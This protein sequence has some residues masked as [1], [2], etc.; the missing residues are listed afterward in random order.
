MAPHNRKVLILVAIAVLAALALQAYVTF[1]T[2]RK[3]RD[4]LNEIRVLNSAVL[5]EEKKRDEIVRLRIENELNSIFW[6]SLLT[7][8]L[9]L[10]SALVAILGAWLG[11]KRYLDTRDKE[12]LDR[13]AADLNE[14]LKGLASGDARTRT[15]GLVGLQYFFGADMAEYH[16]RALAALAAAARLEDD[17]EVLRALRICGEQAFANVKQQHLREVS[18]QGVQMSGMN[19][20]GRDLS[21]L[22]L[23]D[24]HL[25][26]SDLT[27]AKLPQARLSA[28]FL[29]GAKL[30]GADLTD[31]D[32]TYV[33]FAGAVLTGATLS[34]AR[35]HHAKVFDLDIEGADLRQALFDEAALPWELIRHWRRAQLETRLRD[36]LLARYGPEPGGADVVMLMWEVPPLVAG[37]TWTACYHLVRK[38][39]RQGAR[40]TVVVPWSERL[41]LPSPFGSEVDVVA[42]GI[43]PPREETSPYGLGPYGGT[44]AMSSYGSVQRPSQWWS[45]YAGLS[46]SAAPDARAGFGPWSG[47]GAAHPAFVYRSGA[48]LLRLT[49]EFAERVERY[50]AQRDVDVLHGHDWVT[51]KAARR[52][53]AAK[54]IPWIA[55]FHST[56]RERRPE[57]PDPILIDL[58]KKG[59]DSAASIVVPGSATLAR[60]RNDY[61]V[62]AE[63][64]AV[65]PNSLSP[66]DIPLA[67]MGSYEA[68][69]VVF[70]GR[71][72]GQKGPDRFVAIAEAVKRHR[73]GVEFL[74]YGEGEEVG[75]LASSAA[76]RVM[77]R[78]EWSVR[79]TA[80]RNAS[81]LLVTSRS[82]PFGMVILEAMQHRV[83]VLYPA[84]SGAAEVLKSGIRINPADTTACVERLIG[85]LD[86]W[87]LWEQTVEAQAR[88][89]AAYPARDT[90]KDLLALWA[91]VAPA[92]ASAPV[93]KT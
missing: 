92:T 85:L 42:L 88:E 91:R 56:E 35:L 84:E 60:V 59:A 25:E 29:N 12:R 31:A 30:A 64:I 51:F 70:V 33:D 83:P 69:R 74:A 47:Y 55:H 9:P 38:L 53:A 77:G 75:R 24:A 57:A 66:E 22:D 68:K 18:W 36:S 7:G 16:L 17:H 62:A 8:F 78:L 54:G 34:G 43:S 37:G 80:F 76:V 67:D 23:R 48:A 81:A 73:P 6:R 86:N 71:F 41:I 4:V 58:E 61:G 26:D 82:E 45:P 52:S 89:I 11:L 21:G 90:E 63:R 49:E 39:R 93:R 10:A 15:V 1:E 3:S 19:L 28:A 79:G 46:P 87:P 5:D 14:V 72:A 65:V 44:A 40:L 2:S 13:A 50:L 20:S 27:G 32:L